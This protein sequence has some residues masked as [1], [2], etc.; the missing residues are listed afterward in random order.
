MVLIKISKSEPEQVTTGQ[1]W[2]SSQ[3]QMGSLGHAREGMSN[4]I[5]DREGLGMKRGDEEGREGE[6]KKKRKGQKHSKI[7]LNVK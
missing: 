4:T 1:R 7:V 3:Y 6:R 2:T 5:S